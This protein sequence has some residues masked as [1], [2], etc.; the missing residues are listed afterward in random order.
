MKIEKLTENK[1]RVILKDKDFKNISINFDEFLF[2]APETESLFL[3]ILNKAKEEVDFD[4]DGCKLLIEAY[5]ESEDILMFTITKYIGNNKRKISTPKK[6]TNRKKV[7]NYIYNFLS[8]DDFCDFCN[9]IYKHNIKLKDLSKSTVLYF[10]NDTY[11]LIIEKL[12]SSLEG[13]KYLKGTLMEFSKP[14]SCNSAFQVK[15]QEHGKLI[16]KQ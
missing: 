3:E 11:Y 14:V 15:I 7:S 10:Y 5:L 4:T 12:D 2:S 13:F 6:F 9:F 8:F 16:M 1:I